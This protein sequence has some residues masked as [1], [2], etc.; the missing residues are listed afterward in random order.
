[1]DTNGFICNIF[2]YWVKLLVKGP[3]KHRSKLITS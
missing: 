3:S 2:W 1:M